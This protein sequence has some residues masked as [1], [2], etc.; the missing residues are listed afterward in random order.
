ME[1]C[2]AAI[3]DIMTQHD[4]KQ[5]DDSDEPSDPVEEASKESF[6]A[7]DAP[8]FEPLHPGA[9][10]RQHD[11]EPDPKGSDKADVRDHP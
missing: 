1:S 2:G 7:S 11:A 4:P 6:P 9:P 8:F 5:A 3:A 10:P